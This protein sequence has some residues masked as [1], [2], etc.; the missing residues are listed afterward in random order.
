M[1]DLIIENL[2]IQLEKSDI[3]DLDATTWLFL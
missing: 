2:G 1:A 3:S